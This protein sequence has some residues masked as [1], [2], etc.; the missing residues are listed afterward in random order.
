MKNEDDLE[1]LKKLPK[2]WWTEHG[3]TCLVA[4]TLN[5]YGYFVNKDQVIQFFE[6]PRNYQRLID[7]LIKELSE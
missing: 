5:D 3:T 1:W 6:K 7:D 2:G 4:G